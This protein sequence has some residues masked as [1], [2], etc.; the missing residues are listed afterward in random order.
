[1][2]AP[3]SAAGGTLGNLRILTRVLRLS[4]A[5]RSKS[6]W[7]CQQLIVA[8]AE[9]AATPPFLGVT[10]ARGARPRPPVSG[11][12]IGRYRPLERYWLPCQA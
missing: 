1:M 3:I 2:A 5:S 7:C 8:P 4:N 11:P 12:A 10:A 6:E 9:R